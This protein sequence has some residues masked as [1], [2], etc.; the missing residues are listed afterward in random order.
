[1]RAYMPAGA[2]FN[3]TRTVL[4]PDYFAT[5]MLGQVLNNDAQNPL[6]YSR[7]HLRMPTGHASFLPC[8]QKLV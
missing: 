3:G 8:G 4:P 2:V 1:V 5:L 6:V 7:R